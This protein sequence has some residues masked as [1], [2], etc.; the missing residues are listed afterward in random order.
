MVG[1]AVTTFA[2]HQLTDMRIMWRVCII[3]TFVMLAAACNGEE[4]TP[5]PAE[6]PPT[7]TLEP[8]AT[9]IP[10]VRYVLAA[11]TIGYV[12]ELEQL[13]NTAEVTSISESID[14]A[15]LGAAFDIVATYGSYENWTR[16]EVTP[17]VMLVINPDAAPLTPDLADALRRAINPQPVVEALELPGVIPAVAVTTSD[18]AIREELANLGRPDGLQIALGHA[19]VPGAAQVAAQLEAINV[20]TRLL[21]RPNEE[22]QTALE[23]G[24]IQ[25][26]LVTWTTT[27]QQAEWRS[28]FG[29]AYTVD[30]YNL[31]ISYLAVPEL[32]ISFT[33]GGWPLPRWIP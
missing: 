13:E 18:R 21:A 15:S 23:T 27:E 33:P 31:P 22:I 8:E 14:P 16:S 10:P 17:Q 9:G 25:M 11:N 32:S 5:F 1:Y 19:F 7:P 3:L 6:L 12:A 4:A 28:L 20:Q 29:A 30:L 24:R 2:P 26:A